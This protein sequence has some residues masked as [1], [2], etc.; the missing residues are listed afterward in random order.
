MS[1][2]PVLITPIQRKHIRMAVIETCEKR[3]WH[4]HAANVRSNHAHIVSS[5]GA[6][7][8]STALNAFK[9]NATRYMR[10]N[11]SWQN[12][13]SP[14]AERGSKRFLWTEESLWEAVNYVLNGQGDD[15]PEF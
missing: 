15:L 6:A 4:F 14:W 13:F 11:G 2:P 5:I 3:S 8:A 9:A 7:S 10:E 1:R 12:E